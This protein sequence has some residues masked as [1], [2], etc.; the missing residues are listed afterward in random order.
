M[1]S[2]TKATDND[3]FQISHDV[4]V[5]FN[6]AFNHVIEALNILD[7]SDL[8]DED[9]INRCWD[10][11]IKEQDYTSNVG[12][13]AKIIEEALQRI[14]DNHS[15]QRRSIVTPQ[16]EV[17]VP[18]MTDKGDD[19]LP[20]YD[21]EQDAGAIYASFLM[22]YHIDLLN[23]VD[24]LSWFKFSTL[25]ENLSEKTP[26]KKIIAIRSDDL[27]GYIEDPEQLTMIT[28]QQ[29]YYHLEIADEIERQ[30]ELEANGGEL[31]GNL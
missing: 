17:F 21:F 15:Y 6:F 9:K 7:S 29:D 13:R 24:K 4:T 10:V 5:H 12:I 26:I 19:G 11:L 22:Q 18:P 28:E 20:K 16:G 27:S 25:F 8:D 31:F 2:F 14:Q 23:E 1:L 30:R 3:E